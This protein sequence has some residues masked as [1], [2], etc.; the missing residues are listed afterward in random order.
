MRRMGRALA[1]LIAGASCLVFWLGCSDVQKFENQL[2]DRAIVA[3][4]GCALVRNNDLESA[5]IR[6][7]NSRVASDL[8]RI[9]VVSAEMCDEEIRIEVAIKREYISVVEYWSLIY[10]TDQK[11]IFVIAPE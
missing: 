8:T 7:I 11:L 3:S 5:A 9:E 4:R 1:I 2:F 6:E 10:S